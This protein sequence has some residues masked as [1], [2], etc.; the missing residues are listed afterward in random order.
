MQPTNGPAPFDRLSLI[1]NGAEQEGQER[2][3][4]RQVRHA[5]ACVVEAEA[6]HECMLMGEE[7][8][9][10]PARRGMRA[11]PISMSFTVSPRLAR[12][13]SFGTSAGKAAGR[14]RP[15]VPIEEASSSQSTLACTAGL[16]E[17]QQASS[18][19][20][21]SGRSCGVPPTAC[22]A[23]WKG[24]Q[25]DSSTSCQEAPCPPASA[26]HCKPWAVGP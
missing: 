23:P 10:L 22:T 13:M 7:G 17:V 1:L 19:G 4:S 5:G 18:A 21:A 14:H 6:T 20:Q 2:S 3:C 25:K 8:C 24:V 11:L 15:S 16:V 12:I 9:W 26:A